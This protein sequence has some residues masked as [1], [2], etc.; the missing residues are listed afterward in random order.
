MNWRTR[1]TLRILMVALAV[2]IFVVLALIGIVT[3]G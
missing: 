1:E 3:S 2:M